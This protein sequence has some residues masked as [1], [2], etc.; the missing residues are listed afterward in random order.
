M[1]S[2]IIGKLERKEG[3]LKGYILSITIIK[4]MIPLLV[5]CIS[6]KEENTGC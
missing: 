1:V 4:G 3:D 5:N 2:L 6:A